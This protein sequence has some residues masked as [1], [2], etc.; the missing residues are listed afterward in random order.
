MARF[1]CNLRPFPFIGY[2][3]IQ[4][5]RNDR[6]LCSGEDQIARGGKF[7]LTISEKSSADLGKCYFYLIFLTNLLQTNFI[8]RFNQHGFIYVNISHNA[9]R[10]TPT[11]V[12]RKANSSIF[13]KR[14]SFADQLQYFKEATV[15]RRERSIFTVYTSILVTRS[16]F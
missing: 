16:N 15:M 9:L 14:D 5:P 4:I 3:V 1:I 10:A 11:A 2:H 13:E 8:C 7:T 6:F 12:F